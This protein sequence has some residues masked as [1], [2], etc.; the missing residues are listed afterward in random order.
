MPAPALSRGLEGPW[1]RLERGPGAGP[2]RGSGNGPERGV[3][4]K[5]D[6]PTSQCT[7][8]VGFTHPT[9]VP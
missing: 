6:A 3:W 1:F 2:G 8:M 5:S 9:T 4:P 7:G